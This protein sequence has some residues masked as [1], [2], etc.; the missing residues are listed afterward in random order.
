MRRLLRRRDL[1]HAEPDGDAVADL[2][3]VERG[4]REVELH[5]PLGCLHVHP[6]LL[7]VHLGHFAVH[8]VHGILRRHLRRGGAHEG[9]ECQEHGQC[10]SLHG[11]SSLSRG[12]ASLP[13]LVLI[14]LVVLAALTSL[15]RLL[16]RLTGALLATLARLL[17]AL[18]GA[19]PT[20]LLIALLIAV[21][22]LI[23]I[24]LHEP[25]SFEV[26]VCDRDA[27]ERQGNACATAIRRLSIEKGDT[28]AEM[29]DRSTGARALLTESALLGAGKATRA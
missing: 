29:S 19:L 11:L 8:R 4:R 20:L 9:S 1:L 26:C 23:A 13:L 2:H 22:L 15:A 7:R 16:G 12:S 21:L 6:A 5:P 10:Q 27:A 17:P 25:I 28:N 3:V 18:T 24:L 14:A